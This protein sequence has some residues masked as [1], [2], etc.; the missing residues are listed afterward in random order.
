M[1]SIDDERAGEYEEAESTVPLEGVIGFNG[2]T[3]HGLL[4]HPDDKHIIYPLGSTIVVKNLINNTQT[5]LQK[6]GHNSQVSCL[7]LS[8][9][10]K[11]LASGQV[12]HMGFPAVVIVWDME[13]CRPVHRLN[14]HKGKIQD[15]AFSPNETYLATLGGQ[16]D[17]KLVIWDV[18]SGTA[19]CG[20]TASNDSAKTV[21]FLNHCEDE[22]VTGG[23]FNLRTWSLDV[24]NRRLRPFDCHLGQL[25][26]SITSIEIDVDDAFMYCG[27]MTGDVLQVNL[28]TK[29]FKGA[30]PTRRPF[31]QGVLSV[32]KTRNGDIITGAGDGTIALLKAG[33]MKVAR[34]LVVLGGVTSLVLNAAGDHF[35]VGT[36]LCN[37]YLVHVDTFEHEL[38]S[39]C[40]H[41]RINSIAFPEGYSELFATASVNDIRVWHAATCQELLRIQVPNLECFCLTFAQDGKSIISGW[42]DGKIRAFRPQTGR[43]IYAINDAHVDGVTAIAATS[44]N[45][46]VVSGGVDGQV[47][48]W[49]VGAQTQKMIASMK[50]HQGRVNCIRVNDD[51][52]ECVSASDDGSCIVWSLLRF[53]RNNCLFASTQFKSILYHPDQS[54]LLTTGTDRKLTYWDAVDGNP[55]RVMTGSSSDVINCLSVDASGI[56]FVSGGGDKLLRVWGYDDGYNYHT[57]VG[58]SGNIL[59]CAISPDQRIIVSGGD[60]GAIFIWQMPSIPVSEPIGTG[61]YE[62]EQQ[63]QQQQQ[64][65]D[66]VTALGQGIKQVSVGADDQGSYE[67]EDGELYE[68]EEF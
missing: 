29:L 25:K 14:V 59:A 23:N 55:I 8:K 26:R 60:E 33:S 24:Q 63:Y 47:R 50:E 18:D 17:N 61:A 38:R 36:D 31:S 56:R 12:T 28:S 22:L 66:D 19:I 68:E 49:A 7:T 64:D 5:F 53:V 58:H 44:D 27:T 16:D 35:F 2:A 3:P 43:L 1:A 37:V 4:L 62:D 57:A 41:A 10:G 32:T 67:G 54:Q 46:R 6:D 51:N 48:I 52:T 20:S 40:H 21:T 9:S 45:R 30:G 11:Y 42:S 13:T 34:K 15:L 39:T 65:G